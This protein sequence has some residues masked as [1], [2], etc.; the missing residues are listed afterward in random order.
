MPGVPTLNNPTSTMARMVLSPLLLHP[1]GDDFFVSAISELHAHE[2]FQHVQFGAVQAQSDDDEWWGD[3]GSFLS[4][5]RPY[6][7]QDGILVIPVS[8]VLLNKFSYQFGRL[9]TGYQYIEAAFRRGMADPEVRGIAFAI[10]SPGGEVAGNFELVEKMVEM[11]GEKPVRAYAADHAYSAAYSIATAADQIIIS[12]SGGVGSVGVVTAHMDVSRALEEM[13]VKITFI[14]AGDHKVDGNPY[15]QLPDAV[16][17]RIQARIDRIYGEFTSLV[18]SNRGMEE[19]AVRNTEAL[20]YDASDALS[21]GFADRVGAMDEELVIFSRETEQ[22]NELMTTK[23]SNGTAKQGDAAS[24]F[25]QNDVDAARTEGHNE[26]LQAGAAAERERVN[27]ILGSDEG[28]ARPKAA[29]SAA[30]KTDMTAEQAKAFLA[31]LPEE[32]AEQP[33]PTEPQGNTG[34]QAPAPTPF[35]QHMSGPGV[36]AEPTGGDTDEGTPEAQSEA[37]LHALSLATGRKRKAS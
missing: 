6:S 5:L 34:Q 1:Q 22:E 15:E 30:L 23:V 4:R 20:T 17:D 12:R 21:V 26:G 16:K 25:T 7:V 37:M 27:A 35:A 19:Q 9:A 36:G 2:D 32:K 28:K 29:L 13:G 24:T 33:E 10:D 3:E 18:A 31:D 8:G 14:F 11:R